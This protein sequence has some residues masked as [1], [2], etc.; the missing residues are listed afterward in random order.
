MAH[1]ASTIDLD[2]SSYPKHHANCFAG[3]R[4]QVRRDFCGKRELE[5]A[6]ISGLSGA[7]LGQQGGLTQRHLSPKFTTQN[8]I[9]AGG[10]SWLIHDGQGVLIG[11]A[12]YLMAELF[13]VHLVAMHVDIQIAAPDPGS[14]LSEER[15][16]RGK[17][18]NQK[19]GNLFHEG[20]IVCESGS[21]Q[22]Q[23]GLA[24][25]GERKTEKLPGNCLS[26]LIG[27]NPVEQTIPVNRWLVQGNF[28][29]CRYIGHHPCLGR[30]Q[31][32]FPF[33]SN[34]SDIGFSVQSQ[35]ELWV[36]ME[37]AY[38]AGHKIP[39]C[40]E[41]EGFY[42]RFADLSGA[43]LWLQL[44][45]EEEWIG[46]NPHFRGKSRVPVFLQQRVLREQSDLDGA[47]IA[48]ANPLDPDDP[49]SGDFPLVFDVPDFLVNHSDRNPNA[50]VQLTAFSQEARLFEDPEAFQLAQEAEEIPFAAQSFIPV[51]LVGNNEDDSPDAIALITGLVRDAEERKYQFS[52]QWFHWI[53]LETFGMTLDVVVD[54]RALDS[55]PQPG[56]VLQ[57]QAWL[58]GQVV[59]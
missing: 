49:Q 24:P 58:S 36:L 4:E 9:L 40:E 47:Y 46:M 8:G 31:C 21:S 57:V 35:D 42:V 28:A 59:S 41:F 37:Q 51:G 22:P 1:V 26:G 20:N 48:W 11:E 13:Q 53:L 23:P 16:G 3:F 2:D 7:D 27:G 12:E 38:Q 29:S 54:H 17:E 44:D 25:D 43:E 55:V 39:A 15:R 33:M 45:G 30:W 10:G 6:R 18:T 19:K 56:N 34:L 14:L 32:N 5:L 50:S 52:G